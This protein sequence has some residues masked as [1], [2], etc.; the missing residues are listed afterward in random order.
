LEKL[1]IHDT[2]LVRPGY[3]EGIYVGSDSSAAY[4]HAVIGNIIR[5]CRFA[6]G[7]DGEHIDIKEGAE[8]TIV[9]YCTFEGSGMSGGHY[10][11]SFVDVKGVNSII[12]HNVGYRRGNAQIKDAFQ[13]RLMPGVYPS[14]K[15]NVFH[16]NQVDLEGSTGV[17]L[18]AVTGA[19]GT[20]AYANVRVG[21]GK[22]YSGSIS[23]S[24]SSV[25]LDAGDTPAND[26]R[27]AL[28][29][30]QPNPSR[31]LEAIAFTLPTSGDARLDILDVAGRRVFGAEVGP[32]GPGRH[33][34]RAGSLP[35]LAPGIYLITL[36]HAGERRTMRG[37]IL[38]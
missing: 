15:M 14:G 31:S 37:V 36:V 32:L 13:V 38:D 21:G 26:L 2:G 6:G 17:L 1:L 7:I 34:L 18:R 8:G 29:G 28:T 27:L 20:S 23:T 12:H 35:R 33:T 10:A 9:E 11:D 4:A 22:L 30:F 5:S 24:S 3:G 25:A 19:T 16:D